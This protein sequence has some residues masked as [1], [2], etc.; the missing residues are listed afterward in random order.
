MCTTNIWVLL[1]LAEKLKSEWMHTLKYFQNVI[2]EDL[3]H[4]KCINTTHYFVSQ[5]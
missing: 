2:H 3:F 4:N 1:S 5:P